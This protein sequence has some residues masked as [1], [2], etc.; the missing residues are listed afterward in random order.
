MMVSGN[1]VTDFIFNSSSNCGTIALEKDKK[2]KYVLN[3]MGMKSTPY[4]YWI[5]TFCFDIL[6]YLAI[7]IIFNVLLFAFNIK[8][9]IDYIG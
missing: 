3:I 5:G 1:F 9:M 8:S 7:C 4:C 2:L 6:M